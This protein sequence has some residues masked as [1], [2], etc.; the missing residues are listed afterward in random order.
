MY[1]YTR[2]RFSILGLAQLLLQHVLL[3]PQNF[4]L[5]VRSPCRP[6]DRNHICLRNDAGVWNISQKQGLEDRH[7]SGMPRRGTLANAHSLPG[8]FNKEENQ[9][10]SFYQSTFA[11]RKTWQGENMHMCTNEDL[12]EVREPGPANDDPMHNN[13]FPKAIKVATLAPGVRA[14]EPLT[15]WSACVPPFAHHAVDQRTTPAARAET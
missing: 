4:Q 12:S 11:M 7:C 2:T 13:P 10:I 6:F 1:E 5:L 9:T 15:S 8:I 14:R 3:F